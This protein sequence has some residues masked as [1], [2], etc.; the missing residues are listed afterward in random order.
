MCVCMCM[1]VYV[2]KKLCVYVC[3]YVC[4]DVKT[5]YLFFSPAVTAVSF[6][7]ESYSS[8]YYCLRSSVFTG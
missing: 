4:V 2:H 6:A 8:P 7:I 1:C 3:V 5:I